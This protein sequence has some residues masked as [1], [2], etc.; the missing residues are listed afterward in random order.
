[1]RYFVV[2]A[3]TDQLFSGNQAGV[4]LCDAW[5]Q[6]ALMQ[7]IAREG[8]LSDTAFAVPQGDHYGLRWFTPTMEIDLCGHATLA[9]AHVLLMIEHPQQAAV[10]FMSPSGLLTVSRQGD[11]L[12]MNFPVRV[13]SPVEIT[14]TMRAAVAGV[15]ILEAYGGYNLML[16]L[17]D[18]QTVRALTPNLDAVRRL[19]AYHGVIVTAPGGDC[20]FVSRFFAPA[21]GIDEDPVTGS[22]HTSLVPYWAKRLGKGELVARQLSA[23][24][25]TLWCRDEGARIAIAG[26]A[27]LYLDGTL[28]LP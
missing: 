25:G 17:R 15:D 8:K 10:R 16:R 14:D 22:T 9:T 11:R 1:M 4:C 26:Q 27:R 3:F 18:W 5:P 19:D 7:A 24:G 6:D 28:H 13:Q 23:R 20:D 2:D 12:E 21:V